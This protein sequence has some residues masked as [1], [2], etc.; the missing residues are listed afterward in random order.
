MRAISW[1]GGKILTSL[2]EM[3]CYRVIKTRADYEPNLL[4]TVAS[5]YDT[6]LFIGTNI[7]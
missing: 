6:K 7:S 4:K 5:I 3:V 2:L 1:L